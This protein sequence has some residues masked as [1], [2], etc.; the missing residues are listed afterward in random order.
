MNETRPQRVAAE[1]AGLGYSGLWLV[2][3]LNFSSLYTH[4]SS[5]N[6]NINSSNRCCSIIIVYDSIW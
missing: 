3:N 1:Y 6:I 2:D 4:N 5:I